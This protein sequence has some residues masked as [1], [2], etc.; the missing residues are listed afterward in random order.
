SPLTHAPVPVTQFLLTHHVVQRE[1]WTR[2]RDLR[3]PLLR[4]TAHP[5]RWRIRGDQFRVL[6]FKR[7]QLAH[8]H[9]I[10]RVR[11]LWRIHHVIQVL[12]MPYLIAQLLNAFSGCALGHEKDYKKRRASA[13]CASELASQRTSDRLRNQPERKARR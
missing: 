1:H 3:E 13:L 6:F 7:L 11:Y 12:M 2:V 4:L 9:V 8:Q 5:L 10:L